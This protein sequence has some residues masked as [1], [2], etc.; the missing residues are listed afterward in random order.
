MNRYPAKIVKL[1][2]I[3]SLLLLI[4]GCIA[5]K[6]E[7][8]Q[9][10]EVEAADLYPITFLTLHNM[11]LCVERDD[12]AACKEAKELFLLYP[13]MLTRDFTV[14]NNRRIS[15]EEWEKKLDSING[16]FDEIHKRYDVFNIISKFK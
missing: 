8:P 10:K 12:T 16:N 3:A 2:L 1:L 7:Q 9:K 4:S 5:P 15:N 6:Q 11:T 13:W 14:T